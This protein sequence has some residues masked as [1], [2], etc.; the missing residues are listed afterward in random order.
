MHE[1]THYNHAHGYSE[2]HYEICHEIGD[3]YG[4]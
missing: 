1:R 3:Q 2:Q 4:N